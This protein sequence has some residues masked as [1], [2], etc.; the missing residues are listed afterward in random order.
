MKI[1]AVIANNRRRAFEVRVGTKRLAFPYA[2]ATPRP[3]PAD[4]VDSAVAD[5]EL[6]REAISFTLRSG[7]QGFVH[8]DQVLAYNKD[9]T[10]ER[11][12]LLY[13]LTVEAQRRLAA[14]GLS[15]RELIRRLRTSPSQLYRLLDQTNYQK[16]V[17]QV[18]RLLQVLGCDVKVIVRAK[19]A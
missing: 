15:K 2:K 5:E 6:A 14:T 17:D 7:R 16:S 1:G 8:L 12:Q 18:I 4:P 3:T 13:R 19:T 9:P 10:F 11:E